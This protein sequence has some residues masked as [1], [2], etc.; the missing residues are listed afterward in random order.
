MK[1][2]LTQAL[3]TGDI[4]IISNVTSVTAI[5][6]RVARVE[7]IPGHEQESPMA[8]AKCGLLSVLKL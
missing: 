1:Q 8:Q 4:T 6:T 2:L 7:E 5:G 3:K